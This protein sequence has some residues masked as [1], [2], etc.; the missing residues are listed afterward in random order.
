M[1]DQLRSGDRIGRYEL[2]AIVG[3]GGLGVVFRARRDDGELVAVKIMRTHL[4]DDAIFIKRFAREARHASSVSHPHLMPVLDIGQSGS[5]HPYLV[6][7]YVG[8]G[9]L[10]ARIA[11]K[12]VLD[13][14]EVVSVTHQLGSALAALHA[15]D[16]VHR[17]VKPSNVLMG[18]H[19]ALLSDFGLARNRADTLLTRIGATPGTPHYMAPELL[20]GESAS[21]ASDIYALASVAY[22]CLAGEPPHAGKSLKVRIESPPGAPA[23][24]R[25]DVP[26]DVGA[27]VL[28]GLALDP[29]SR[30]RTPVAFAELLE[31]A[32]GG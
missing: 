12:G 14:A 11:A 1:S 18:E 9:T 17:D 25:S 31:A 2:E 5:R 6:M 16:V 24:W 28:S 13:L 27:A 20:Y 3:R 30:P 23:L 32:A 26:L 7:P 19:G 4:S 15:I 8:G 22:E 21:A 10:A 29:S